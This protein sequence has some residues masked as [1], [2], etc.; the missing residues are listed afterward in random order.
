MNIEKFILDLL[1]GVVEVNFQFIINV[2][3]VGLIIFW[4]VVLGW[5]WLDSG[6]R[7]SNI[8]KRISYFLLV[9]IFNIVG[10]IIYLIIRPNETIEEIYWSD[11]ERR[12]LKYET[13][14]LGDCPK[15][16][17]QLLPGFIFCPNCGF[18]LKIKCSQCD[19][20]VDR[21]YKL[22]PYCSNRVN[23][24]SKE[25]ESPSTEVME[26]QIKE[27]KDQATEVVESKKTRYKTQQDIFVKVGE[28]IVFVYG[29]IVKQ[30]KAIIPDRK[31]NTEDKKQ[32]EL[33]IRKDK[34]KKTKKKSKRR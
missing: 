11:L 28:K 15:C 7:T 6:E 26:Q 24:S 25:E 17:F 18:E 13:S 22:C 2:L 29:N 3:F 21:N 33:Q 4:I 30:I 31:E 32:I 34:K 14:E 10:W 1:N 9:A 16:G 8:Y 5:V 27:S 23:Y 12:Y 19:V 20:Y